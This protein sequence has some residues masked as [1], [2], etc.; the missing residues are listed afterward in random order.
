MNNVT[1]KSPKGVLILILLGLTACASIIPQNSYKK[2]ES[3]NVENEPTY[4]TSETILSRKPA[5]N[6]V[7]LDIKF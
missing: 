1:N 3:P 5:K 4:S 2:N 6:I 7:E